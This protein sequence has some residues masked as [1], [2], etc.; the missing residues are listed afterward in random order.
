LSGRR[1][2]VVI[3]SRDRPQALARCLTGVG[4]LYHHPFEVVV[5]ADPAGCAAV[6]AHPLGRRVKL[7]PFG[8]ANIAAA[9][10]AGIAAAGGE[11]VAFID[12]DAVPEPT[13]LSRLVA[14]LE[15][16]AAAT[17]GFVRGRNGISFQWRARVVAPTGHARAVTV[18]GDAPFAPPVPDGGAVKTEGTNMAIQRSVLV[19]LGGFDPRFR[20]YLDETD[21]N[22]RLARA[23]LV[24]LLVPGAQVHHGFAAS[25][26]R[27]AN[28]MPTDLHDIGASSELFWARHTPPGQVTAA[29]AALV[30]EQTA[31]LRRHMLGLRCGPR[32]MRRL[33]ASLEAGFADGRARLD[34]PATASLPPPPEFQPLHD[35]APAGGMVFLGGRVRQQA[36]LLDEARA[37]VARG[38]RASVTVLSHGP[39][40]HRVSFLPEGIWLQ[41]GGLWGRAQRDRREWPRVTGFAARLERE[42]KR[43]HGL[44]CAPAAPD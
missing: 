25:E 33:M 40:R 37:V 11:A 31:R 32:E 42:T 19:A 24:T 41:S 13:W 36:A 27:R 9:R 17:G 23:G 26:R 10:N 43:V 4:Q 15:D 29:R 22:L 30:A 16:G 44:R 1:A 28:R 7:V 5:V 6:R 12:D 14:P 2:S 35:A 39:R 34:D 20:F 18:P 3:V 38:G 8:E 21:L